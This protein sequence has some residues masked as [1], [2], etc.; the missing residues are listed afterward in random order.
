MTLCLFQGK[1]SAGSCGQPV[2]CAGMILIEQNKIKN[3]DNSSGHYSP[4]INM[5]AKALDVFQKQGLITNNETQEKV[6]CECRFNYLN[7]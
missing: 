6:I 4:P 2:I 1:H 3:F 5:L 7:S